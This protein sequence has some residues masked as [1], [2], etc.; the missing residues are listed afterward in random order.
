MT[1]DN[2]GPVVSKCVRNVR[3]EASATNDCT[4]QVQIHRGD[5]HPQQEAACV[6]AR[7]RRAE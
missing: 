2:T 5:A 4:A 1:H 7:P 3:V 6:H